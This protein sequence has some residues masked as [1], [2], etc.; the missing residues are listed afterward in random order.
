[1]PEGVLHVAGPWPICSRLAHSRH[2]I[3]A[4]EE[5][6]LAALCTSPHAISILGQGHRGRGR[7]IETSRMWAAEP[8]LFAQRVCPF[9]VERAENRRSRKQSA[10]LPGRGPGPGLLGLGGAAGSARGLPC[11]GHALPRAQPAGRRQPSSHLRK[12][13]PQTEPRAGLPR[14]VPW[15]CWKPREWVV[16]EAWALLCSSLPAHLPPTT[17]APGQGRRRWEASSLRHLLSAG[18]LPCSALHSL[19]GPGRWGTA[20]GLKGLADSRPA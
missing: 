17:A 9:T 14:P 6:A 12:R 5:W 4:P 11:L 8:S 16:T 1:M 15:P 3:N 2:S 19:E 20:W 13:P 10:A 7:G 18:G